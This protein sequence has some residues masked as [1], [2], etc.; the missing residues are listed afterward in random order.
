[1]ARF[2]GTA[3]GRTA[4]ASTIEASFTR[5]AVFS[6]PGTTTFQVPPDAKKAKVFVIGAGS[7]YRSGTYCFLSDNCCSGVDFPRLCY[8]TCFV[9]HLTGAGGGY[10]EK[11]YDSGIAG[12]TLTIN[13]GSV[14]GL[15][16]SSVAVSGYTTVNA[17]NATDTVHSWACTGNSSARDNSVDNPVAFNFQLPRCG[18]ANFISG[19][20]NYGGCASGGDINRTGGRG[21]LIPEFLYDGYLDGVSCSTGSGGFSGNTSS[22][23]FNPNNLC[24]C[25]LGYHYTFGSYCGFNNGWSGQYSCSC[26]QLCAAT[27]NLCSCIFNC[28]RY[29]SRFSFA[30]RYSTKCS[31]NI[32]G[33][34]EGGPGGVNFPGSG[35]ISMVKDKPIGIG[36]Q[37]GNS[38]DAG[39][40][41]ASEQMV[42]SV[43]YGLDRSSSGSGSCCL[44]VQYSHYSQGYDYSFGGTQFSCFCVNYYPGCFS[45]CYSMK[46][47][48]TDQWC[49]RCA[50]TGWTYVFGTNFSGTAHCL[51]TPYGIVNCSGANVSDCR[52]RFFNIGYVND[53]SSIINES[54]EIPLST[55][56]RN[57]ATNVNDIRYG[58]GAT[59]DSAAGY[60][61][62]GNRLNPTGGQGLVVVVYG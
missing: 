35:D 54:W 38:S 19:Y 24:N 7:N 43:T 44:Q 40:R 34:V 8:C 10:A 61:G 62:G 27:V 4:G 58:N 31:C 25:M 13:V 53:R 26:W 37:S 9:G 56:I 16:A 17:T 48:Q 1:M 18:Y 3:A 36:A 28:N 60:G 42:T 49:Y 45:N 29:S 21:V 11:T 20:Y 59:F 14:G 5:A 51:C 12:K 15:S 32:S 55:L 22:C 47:T 23:W 50:G 30:G 39:K 6:T 33:E 52:N 41:G 46:G 57:N 2:L